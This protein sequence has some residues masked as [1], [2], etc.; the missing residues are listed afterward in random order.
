MR[1]LQIIGNLDLG[2]AETL[3]CDLVPELRR[4][5]AETEVLCLSAREFPLELELVRQGITPMH[6]VAASPYSP[7]QI[8]NVR[9]QVL[10]GNYDVVH[11][12]LFPEQLWACLGVRL[13]NRNIPLVTT[14]HNTWNRRRRKVFW[15]LDR[16]MYAQYASV[17]CIGTSTESALKDWIGDEHLPTEVILNGIVVERFRH[18]SAGRSRSVSP[19]GPVTLICVAS[20][21]DRKGQ[22]VLLQAASQLPGTEVLLVGEGPQRAE[23]EELA[24]QLKMTE[25]VRFLGIRRDIPE[26][27]AA[28]SI[29]VQPSHWEG[30][31]IA[32]VEAMAAGLP[33][34]ASNVAGLREV[35]GGAGLLFEP[36]SAESLRECIER[37]MREAALRAQL[38]S[39]AAERAG[40][41]SI[42]TTA[43]AYLQVYKSVCG[44]P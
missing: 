29:Y 2:G 41:F 16:W 4:L 3:L 18:A 21:T 33:V 37:L 15:P 39:M 9:K 42:E 20:L 12:H 38:G 22:E 36:G 14:E 26:L 35:V 13:A 32:T 19:P 27:L 5:G 43:R 17:I 6:A 11:S 31:G 44:M 23:L 40:L 8:L 28:A 25:R 30:F 7:R 1:V 34:V 10:E 24:S